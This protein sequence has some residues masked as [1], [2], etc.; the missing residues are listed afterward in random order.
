MESPK[1]IDLIKQ[2]NWIAVQNQIAKFLGISISLYT[3]E[4]M[5]LIVASEPQHDICRI[6]CPGQTFEKKCLSQCIDGIKTR[7]ETDECVFFTCHANLHMFAISLQ[8]GDIDIV[9]LGGKVY[10]SLREFFYTFIKQAK[11]LNLNEDEISTLSNL[12]KIES[13][14]SLKEAAQ[15][16]Q[17]MSSI[18][19]TTYLKQFYKDR[20]TQTISLLNVSLTLKEI[21]N[22]EEIFSTVLNSL[23]LLFNIQTASLLLLNTKKGKYDACITLGNQ[24]DILSKISLD[25][26]N[27]FIKKVETTKDL[28]TYNL[29]HDAFKSGFPKEVETATLMP[30]FRNDVLLGTLAIFNSKLTKEELKTISFLCFYISVILENKAAH[31]NMETYLKN[32]SKFMRIIKVFE[33]AA[34]TEELFTVI[35]MK[36]AEFINADLGSLMI[37]EP[38]SKEL[39]IKAIKGIN[40]KIVEFVRIA[41]GEGIS[42]KVFSS[43]KAAIVEDIEHDDEFSQKNKPRYKTKSF[44]SIPLKTQNKVIGILNLADKKNGRPFNNVDVKI[45]NSLTSYASLAIERFSF[46]KQS[47][48]LKK[49]SITDPLTNLLNRHFFQ[50]RLI[51]EIER[52]KRHHL[53]LSL[54]ILDI[55]NF[56]TINDTYGHPAGDEALVLIA[57]IISNTIRSIDVA[58]RYGGEEF[59]II[60]PQT[61]KENAFDIAKRICDNINNTELMID[62]YNS[63]IKSSVSLGLATFPND[64]STIEELIKN[65]DIA[66][67]TAKA[68]GKNRVVLFENYKV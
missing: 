12:L 37:Y 29:G 8:I 10:H 31:K 47:E 67:Y 55:D 17:T 36:I 40:Q 19:T 50:E 33:T 20:F 18:L 52:A 63:P 34:A 21:D 15:F 51:E 35:L 2:S 24:K 49:I 39:Y 38:T 60:L 6:F 28:V 11:Q 57:Q 9:I 59:T 64:A 56:K 16:T 68:T 13:K 65:T 62:E 3:Q 26:D 5:K 44:V 41:P 4:E 43:G 54:I 61:S 7:R 32:I 25:V 45:L 53:P 27:E 58:A 66:L 46:Q 22:K 42:G 1:L 14:Q 30:I 23:I 48:K